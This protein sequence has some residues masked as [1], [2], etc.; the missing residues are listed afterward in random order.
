[1]KFRGIHANMC[2]VLKADVVL[3][4]QLAEARYYENMADMTI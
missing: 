3:Q 2:V 1:M 4:R